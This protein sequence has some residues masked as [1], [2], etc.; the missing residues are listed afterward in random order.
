[1]AR[2]RLTFL[3]PLR[4]RPFRL[5]FLGQVISNLGD[6]LNLLALSSLLVVCEYPIRGQI[7]ALAQVEC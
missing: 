7:L 4:H 1:M 6:W 2:A 5:L 3:A